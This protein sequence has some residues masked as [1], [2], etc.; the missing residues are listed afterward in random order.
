MHVLLQQQHV[1]QRRRDLSTGSIDD[2]SMNSSAI[3]STRWVS[4]RMFLVV[5]EYSSDSRWNL[6]IL[7]PHMNRASVFNVCDFFGLFG[8][9]VEHVNFV[10]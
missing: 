3:H 4:K 7:E 1:Q 6:N 10:K 9:L 2:M 5:Y 8:V